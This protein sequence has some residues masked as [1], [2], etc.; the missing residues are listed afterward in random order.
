MAI[1]HKDE[2][3]VKSNAVSYSVDD[4]TGLFLK[5]QAAMEKTL[6]C[7]IDSGLS[8][9]KF[10]MEP[11]PPAKDVGLV[12]VA[13]STHRLFSQHLTNLNIN[14]SETTVVSDYSS[15][16]P[17]LHDVIR[18]LEANSTMIEL[19]GCYFYSLNIAMFGNEDIVE[20]VMPTIRDR[21]VMG[22]VDTVTHQ[23]NALHNQLD[24]FIK[25]HDARLKVVGVE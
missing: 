10:E 5:T 6:G 23:L 8:V 14:V 15:I 1:R 16:P 7:M 17:V 9:D 21:S 18:C 2:L 4:M 25:L 12:F 11:F 13:D 22:L 19:V 3:V 20:L 24:I